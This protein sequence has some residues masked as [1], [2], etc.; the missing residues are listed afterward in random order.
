MPKML[1]VRFSYRK[2]RG[3]EKIYD[4]FSR[5]LEQIVEPTCFDAPDNV[6]PALLKLREEMSE[7]ES[8]WNF[9]CKSLF[10]MLY[11]DVLRLL[12]EDKIE[13]TSSIINDSRHSRYYHIEMWFAEN[14]A[15][16]VTEGDLAQKMSLSKRQ[17]SRV[18]ADIYGMSFR[19]KLTEV[20]LHRAAQ[21][22]EQTEL[23]VDKIAL[24]VGYRSFSGFHR[25]FVKFFG[26][27][28]FEYRKNR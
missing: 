12:S 1:A 2:I 21:L 22:L 11:I 13:N 5:A 19:D 15:K 16:H 3:D 4:S 9:V 27:T 26:C 10:V 17:L 20:R 25:A 28:P 23:N 8:A 6:L 7:R 18:F 14:L 24:A